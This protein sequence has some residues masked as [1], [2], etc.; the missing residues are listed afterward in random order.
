M[1]ESFYFYSKVYKS[2]LM[3]RCLF[4]ILLYKDFYIVTSVAA[5]IKNM[6]WLKIGGIGIFKPR[7][8]KFLP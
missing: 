5:P 2:T 4:K 8:F 3:L 6:I 1:L 7:N